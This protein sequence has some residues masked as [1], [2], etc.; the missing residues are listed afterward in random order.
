MSEEIAR[1][2]NE[3]DWAT[4]RINGRS[5]HGVESAR[6]TVSAIVD[7]VDMTAKLG[8]TSSVLASGLVDR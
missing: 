5:E 6:E 1:R 7:E 3:S 4:K 8:S 2:L